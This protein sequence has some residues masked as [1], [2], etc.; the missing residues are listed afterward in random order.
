MNFTGERN[1]QE[2][3][4]TFEEWRKEAEQM[5]MTWYYDD[6]AS[7][8]K[9]HWRQCFDCNYRPWEAARYTAELLH[10]RATAPV[11]KGWQRPLFLQTTGIRDNIA[12]CEPLMLVSATD[13]SLKDHLIALV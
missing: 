6:P 12:A 1:W 2:A 5:L 8:D 7:V 13:L 3:A 9:D 11:A 10:R 4:M